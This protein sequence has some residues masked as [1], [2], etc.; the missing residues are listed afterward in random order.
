MSE[1]PLQARVECTDGPCGE[2]TTLIVDAKSLTVSHVV[3]REDKPGH[4]ERI[5]PAKRVVET[6]AGAIRLDCSVEELHA[7]RPFLQVEYQQAYIPRYVGPD[8]A[9]PYYY[10]EMETI[11]V[12]QELVPEGGRS[13]HPGDPVEASDGRVGELSELVT[14]PETGRITHLVLREG[15]LWGNKK[16]LLPASMI[17]SR[18]P[19]GAIRLHADKKAIAALLAMP[20]RQYYGVTD[21]S[22]LIWTFDQV[23]PAKAGMRTLKHLSKQQRAALLAA[24]LLVKDAEGKATMEEMGDVDKKHGALFGAVTGGLLGLVGGPLGLAV[25]AAA[26]A[27]TGR[28]AARRIDQGFPEEFLKATTTRLE[29]GRSA[30]LALAQKG[31]VDELAAALAEHGGV[32]QQM[33]VTDELLA[34]LAAE[35]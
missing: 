18:T 22:L 35:V 3:V 29:A 26:G 17:E 32:F 13:V 7:M 19:E 27:A 10:A 6:T 25:G 31:G 28:A 2:S 21:T 9:T 4:I 30:I 33:A 14:D 12:V 11:P 16:V 23:E 34:R 5:V 15:H 8:M 1:I 24:A 20:A